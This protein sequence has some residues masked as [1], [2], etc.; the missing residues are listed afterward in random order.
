MSFKSTIDVIQSTTASSMHWWRGTSTMVTSSQPEQPLQLY[1]FEACP[2]CRKVREVLT[3]LDLDAMIY[4]CPKSGSRYRDIV[5]RE[6]GKAQF[7]YFVDP[8]TQ[9]GMYESEDIITY[10][11][12]T[13]GNN[14]SLK[15]LPAP[16]ETVGA[17]LVSGIRP[18]AGRHAR[19]SRKPQQPLELYSFE[20]SPYSRR[21][22]EV[23]CELEI[24]YL[25]RNTG[26]ALWR[27]MGPPQVRKMLFPKLPVKGRN[28]TR[29]LQRTG[30]VQVPYLID[31]NTGTEMFESDDI[32][33]YL[34]QT[35]A[36]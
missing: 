27:D 28:R 3:E 20:S 2:Y 17:T 16:L 30:Q 8:N 11:R 24:P 15:R 18:N 21:V 19:P 23:L 9:T 1:E 12:Q 32:I 33:A 13:Y 25:L 31:P 10:L 5:I 4:P 34:L 36:D 26:K 22:R 7:P 35:Y 6:G 29:L 14:K